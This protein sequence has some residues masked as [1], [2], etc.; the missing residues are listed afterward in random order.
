MKTA[1]SKL[2]PPENC[3]VCGQD[4]PRSA[5][6]C[7]GCGAD[8]NSGWNDEATGLDGVDLPGENFSYAQFVER[9][10]GGKVKPAGQKTAW[11]VVGIILLISVVTLFHF[12][13]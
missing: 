1:D 7:P 11:W 9:E 5:L 3:P 12:P 10:F 6:A 13:W 4:V 2:K 8:H